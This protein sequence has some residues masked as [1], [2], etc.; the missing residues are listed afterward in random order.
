MA[1]CAEKWCGIYFSGHSLAA[2]TH[3]H[4]QGCECV[5]EIQIWE[6][7]Q[8]SVDIRSA[9]SDPVPNFHYYHTR[10]DIIILQLIICYLLRVRRTASSSWPPLN[11]N[12]IRSS[13]Y[14]NKLLLL[15]W[16]W[17]LPALPRLPVSQSFIR[18]RIDMFGIAYSVS[19]SLKLNVLNSR[20]PKW[21][22]NTVLTEAF[23]AFR[24]T[25][26][27]RNH[28]SYVCVAGLLA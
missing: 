26:V 14:Y 23:C 21:I 9:R 5:C 12:S 4:E 13:H 10:I 20:R 3:T 25:K 17:F 8:I 2:H 16:T 7:M 15:L 24:R 27:K 11:A 28:M 1:V 19:F 6:R 18:R 22:H